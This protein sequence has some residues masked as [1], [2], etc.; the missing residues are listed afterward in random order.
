MTGFV[1]EYSSH[2]RKVESKGGVKDQQ[3][4]KIVH[5]GSIVWFRSP[6]KS[7]G[8][9]LPCLTSMAA[10]FSDVLRLLPSRPKSID[11]A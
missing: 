6:L 2:G 11:N 7:F 4:H 5:R 1:D 3:L 8:S 9:A 10:G